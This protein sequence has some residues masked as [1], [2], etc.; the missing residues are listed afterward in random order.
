MAEQ[1]AVGNVFEFAFFQ[2]L[3][4]ALSG[5]HHIAGV[6]AEFIMPRIVV[7]FRGH[8]SARIRVECSD[9]AAT[10]LNFMDALHRAHVVDTGIKAQF[11]HKH[12]GTLAG[13]VAQTE[14]LFG[15]ITCGNHMFAQYD[16]VLRN[17]QV[18]LWG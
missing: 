16:T 1:P 3:G 14:Y 12:Q 7:A 17:L 5:Q 9:F 6:P 18:H 2:E 10:G 4:R 11:V 8:Q 15:N 13:F